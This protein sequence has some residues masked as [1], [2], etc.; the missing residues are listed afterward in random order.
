MEEKGLL[1]CWQSFLQALSGPWPRQISWH[2]AYIGLVKSCF[3]QRQ[4][5]VTSKCSVHQRKK[6][7]SDFFLKVKN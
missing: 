4:V 6:E 7:K 1:W 5:K 2:D 3:L